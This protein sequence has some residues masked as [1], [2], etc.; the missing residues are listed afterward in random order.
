MSK[1]TNH[2]RYLTL[3]VLFFAFA[4]TIGCVF[5]FQLKHDERIVHVAAIMIDSLDRP[6]GIVKDDSVT[7]HSIPIDSAFFAEN[8]DTLV[9][10]F[11][12]SHGL[13]PA[14]TANGVII[15]MPTWQ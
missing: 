3:S 12:N 7:M 14:D 5:V 15:R 13:I 10:L 4:L 1:K 2:R 6:Y 11:A 9:S 8:A